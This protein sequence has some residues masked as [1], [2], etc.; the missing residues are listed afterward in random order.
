MGIFFH[1]ALPHSEELSL[2]KNLEKTSLGSRW[3]APWDPGDVA[4]LAE[5]FP[6]V[7]EFRG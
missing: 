4:Q 3:K 6:S 2:D 5:C 1:K 7:H